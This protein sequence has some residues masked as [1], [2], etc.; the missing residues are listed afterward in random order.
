MAG[1]VD[2][3]PL[4]GVSISFHDFG[5]YGAVGVHRPLVL[6][7]GLPMILTRVPQA[8]GDA[9]EELDGLVLAPG[10]DIEPDL[11]GQAPDPKLAETDPERDRF[12]FEL[13]PRA[14]D[15]GVPIL[16]MCRG[17]Q[18][19]NVALGGTLVQDLSLVPA[20]A[21]HPSDPGWTQ[22]KEVEHASLR[23]EPLP[24]HPRHAIEI[25]PGCILAEALGT[26]AAEV[27]SFHHQALDRLGEGVS[28]VAR[29]PDGVPEAIELPGS[30]VFAT[31]WELQEE[32][33]IDPRFLRVFERFVAA[34]RAHVAGR[35]ERRRLAPAPPVGHNPG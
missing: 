32:W 34:A 15:R 25:E 11:Y 12:E 8:L 9:V 7:G 6:A 33:R 10:R 1:T 26:Q 29:A 13:V 35:A 17:I 24:S 28:V 2:R 5:D 27:C 31:Q 4:I 19:L 22:W 18:V 21:G 14:L 3:R 16:G 20:W 23:D 30:W